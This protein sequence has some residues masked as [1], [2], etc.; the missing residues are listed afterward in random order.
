MHRNFLKYLCYF[1]V[2]YQT[3]LHM[4]RRNIIISVLLLCTC[5]LNLCAQPVKLQ[6]VLQLEAKQLQDK[7]F[8]LYAKS[9]YISNKDSIYAQYVNQ[10]DSVIKLSFNISHIEK[11][12]LVYGKQK[13]EWYAI[14]NKNYSWHLQNEYAGKGTVKPLQVRFAQED[15]LNIAM[16]GFNYA[17]QNFIET[18]FVDLMRYRDKAVYAAFEKEML[19]QL[20]A[21][22]FKDSSVKNFFSDYIVYRLAKLRYTAK[23]E[24]R[25]TLIDSLYTN[26]AVLYNNPAYMDLFKIL[27]DANQ[28]TV[29]KT[30]KRQDVISLLKVKSSLDDVL[31]CLSSQTNGHITLLSD[32]VF[33][34]A[35]KSVY[36]LKILHQ[37]YLQGLLKT[38]AA[39]CAHPYA[40]KVARH[41]ITTLN[42]YTTGRE[43]KPYLQMLGLA[44]DSSRYLA[45]YLLFYNPNYPMQA[46]VE[47]LHTLALEANIKAVCLYAD[48]WSS[49][50]KL[51]A[52]SKE[53]T[54][55]EW[56]WFDNRYDILKLMGVDVLPT[57]YLLD[58]EGKLINA[59][60][61]KA[62]EH[63]VIK[64]LLQNYYRQ[65]KSSVQY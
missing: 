41:L 55:I 9:D 2:L 18:S 1:C 45:T 7:T 47:A 62:H 14:P 60:A 37:G 27:F 51:P 57:Y 36:H 5:A 29:L 13:V 44:Q 33:L 34:Q 46:D 16:D 22:P 38:F 43:M 61:P 11:M 53:Y 10:S 39:Q 48:I 64:Q 8:C 49:K 32:L 65:K 40:Q 4:L 20:S 25:Q 24:S 12:Q 56:L 63:Q 42:T 23:I 58:N 3:R 31:T 54:N 59:A 6:N 15:M 21:T 28:M 30:G 26:Q 52:F 19:Q 50:N 17:Y 35:I